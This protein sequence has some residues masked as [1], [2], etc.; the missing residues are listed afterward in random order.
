[1]VARNV[2]TR[3]HQNNTVTGPQCGGDNC[4]KTGSGSVSVRRAGR[5]A[6]DKLDTILRTGVIS[7]WHLLQSAGKQSPRPVIWASGDRQEAS[8]SIYGRRRDGARFI[9]SY[10]AYF[11]LICWGRGQLLKIGG[12]MSGDVIMGFFLVGICYQR[13]HNLF[14]VTC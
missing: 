1:M 14:V 12:R 8:G 6:R 10:V 3:Y 4:Y 2:S 5:V 7:G 11:R 9:G 13:Y